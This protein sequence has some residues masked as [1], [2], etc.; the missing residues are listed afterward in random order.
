MSSQGKFYCPHNHNNF[1]YDKW[2]RKSCYTSSLLVHS[3]FNSLSFFMTKRIRYGTQTAIACL[4]RFTVI[5]FI[6]CLRGEKF[7][8]FLDFEENC[9]KKTRESSLGVVWVWRPMIVRSL[10]Y[11]TNKNATNWNNHNQVSSGIQQKFGASPD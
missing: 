7:F 11:C 8:G 6:Q 9:L 3:S 2:V 5:S 4:W 10:H 1:V